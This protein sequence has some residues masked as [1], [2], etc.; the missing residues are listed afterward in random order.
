M[1]L[2]LLSGENGR[3]K[4][5]DPKYAEAEPFHQRAL[6]IREHQAGPEDPLV[7]ASL[8]GLAL[9]YQA[10]GKYTEA[11]PLFKRALHIQEQQLGPEHPE[12]AEVQHDFAGFQ[13]AQG[14]S[15]EAAVLYQH[16]LMTR[17][18]V[19]GPSGGSSEGKKPT[20]A[21][22]GEIT[23]ICSH[24]DRK[25]VRCCRQFRAVRRRLMQMH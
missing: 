10:Q 13:L 4:C 23:S 8:N 25:L 2:L 17:E 18:H 5:R 3:K 22:K 19:F 16:A 20:G 15:L 11:E 14:K 21:V 1:I 9:L 12:T 6:R 24:Q 7:A